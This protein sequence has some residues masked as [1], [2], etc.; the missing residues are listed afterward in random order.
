[1]KPH[2]LPLHLFVIAGSVL[3]LSASLDVRGLNA[4]IPDQFKNLKVLPKD[5]SKEDL[6]ATMR[7]LASALGE[8]CDFCHVRSE[9]PHGEFNW[10]SDDKDTKD[11]A[12]D[13]LQMVHKINADYLSQ[14]PTS[15]FE[16]VQVRCETC[17]RG[18][19]RPFLIQDVLTA[20]YKS[21]GLDS[22]ESKY[23]SLRKDYYGSDTYNFSAKMLPDLSEGLLG[24]KDPQTA[25]KLAEFEMKWYPQSGF[26]YLMRG[27]ANAALGKR[28][29]AIADLS[30]AIELSPELKQNAQRM[31]DRLQAK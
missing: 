30:K 23:E 9:G 1:M 10:A 14:L 18:Q 3:F 25:L 11:T 22:L 4:Q 24:Q 29:A 6:L 26:G 8:R 5:I 28:D 16:R 27:Q 13:M 31:I 15:H 17:H 19:Q 21:G 20:S 2:F 12:R 7:S